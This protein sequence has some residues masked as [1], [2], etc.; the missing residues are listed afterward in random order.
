MFGPKVKIS[1]DLMEKIKKYSALAG[2][3]SP[4]EFV[5]HALEKEIAKL[6]EAGSDEEI[7]KKLQ[8]LGYIS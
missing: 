4:D 1:K 7:K 5:L 6:E 3:S 2:Y 8:G